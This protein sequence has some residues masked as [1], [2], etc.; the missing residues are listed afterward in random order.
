MYKF[1]ILSVFFLFACTSHSQN[2]IASLPPALVESSALIKHKCS[3][4]SLNDSGNKAKI[5]VFNKKGKIKHSCVLR[6]ATNVD[7]EAMAYDGKEFLYIGDIGN[8][9]NKRKDLVVYKVRIDEVLNNK[10]VEAEKISF[11]YPEQSNFPPEEAQL[12]YDAEAMVVKENVLGES[13]LLIF[14]KNR[15][16]PFDGISKIYSLPLVPGEYEAK[17]LTNLHLPATNWREES[18]TDAAFYNQD[19][20]YILTYAKLYMYKYENEKWVQKK[21]YL[22]DSWTQKEGIAVDKKHIYLTDEN[23]SGIFTSNYLYKL[24]K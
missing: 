12:Y 20:L 4:L 16:V 17:L 10:S 5:L 23:E 13:E 19:E 11:H 24:K 18:I 14:T 3:F 15:T 22:H 21:E 1:W 7:W 2:K 6:N 8:N 9:E